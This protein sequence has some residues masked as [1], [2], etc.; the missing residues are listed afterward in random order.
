MADKVSGRP[1]DHGVRVKV[2]KGVLTSEPPG[3]QNGKSDFI[4]LDAPPVGL[5][6]N[7]KVLGETSVFLLG[8][9]YPEFRN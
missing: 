3:E 5:T 8:N 4:E 2:L 6:A 1:Q 7:P 9:I